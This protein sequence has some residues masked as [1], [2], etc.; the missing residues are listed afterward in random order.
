MKT[1]S[2]ALTQLGAR[3]C[4]PRST[5][6]CKAGS[7]LADSNVRDKDMKLKDKVAIVTG[8]ARGIGAAIVERYV[9][10]GARVA[11]ADLLIDQAE[12][13]AR[14]HGDRAFAVA[15]DVT[16]RDSSRRAAILSSLAQAGSTFSSTTPASLIW[17]LSSK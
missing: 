14:R 1:F 10:E 9:A 2:D 4:G 11:I 5:I 7:E 16:K 13:T 3:A 12:E 6:T 8:G 15:L 17:A